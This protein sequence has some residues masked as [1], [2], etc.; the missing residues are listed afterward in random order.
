MPKWT[1]L[2]SR[3]LDVA[4][5]ARYLTKRFITCRC[6][7]IVLFLLAFITIAVRIWM[8][9]RH[10]KCGYCYFW[11]SLVI[12]M[13]YSNCHYASLF[14]WLHKHFFEG[15]QLRLSGYLFHLF[16]IVLD[17]F[18]NYHWMSFFNHK[19]FNFPDHDSFHV[20]LRHQVL[21][22]V[23][24]ANHK[25]RVVS[26]SIKTNLKPVCLNH[27]EHQIVALKTYQ[28][29]VLKFNFSLLSKVKL[30]FSI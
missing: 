25:L 4:G 18:W 29:R 21:R 9:V 19:F 14:G 17:L 13:N 3:H 1:G 16:A 8:C 27:N 20:P 5:P 15:P 23:C 2:P 10:L 22:F 28:L 11:E 26:S 24:P 7:R 6:C 30:S 12:C